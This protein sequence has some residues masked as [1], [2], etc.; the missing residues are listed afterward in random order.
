MRAKA[1]PGRGRRRGIGALLTLMSFGA[2][3]AAAQEL[4]PRAYAPMP[5][6]GN[7][8]ML[9]YGRSSGGVLFD[10]SLPVEDVHAVINAG[11]LLYG[12]SFGLFGRSANVVV[13]LPYAWGE[14]SGLLAGEYQRLT[15][16]GLADIRGQLSVN[17]LGGPALA[18]REFVKHRPRTILGLSLAVAA[19]TG[20]YDP[21][22]LVNI[23]SNRWS[24]KPEV[25]FSRTKGRWYLELYSGVWIFGTND[26]FFGGSV[27]KQ[28]PIGT[29][30]AHVSYTFK[31]RLWLAGD[32]TFYTGG[33]TTV[34]GTA[35]ADL[36]SNSRLGAALA[37]P[38]GRRSALKVSWSTGFTTRIGADFSSIGVGFQTVWQG[39]P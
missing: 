31:P 27:R 29:F 32:A 16:S 22:K 5:T 33:R 6:G 23:G 37:L 30:Q 3:G 25:G 12:H 13:A 35:K 17:L 24:V 21:A 11:A 28:D 38:V 14:M 15:R 9:S 18:P 34:D 1:R 4:N 20:Q 2:A 39:R 19:P 7:I 10:P 8:A 36:Q 26:D